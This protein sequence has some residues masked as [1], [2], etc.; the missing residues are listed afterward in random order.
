VPGVGWAKDTGNGV[1][2]RELHWRH[3]H[4]IFAPIHAQP[5]SRHGTLRATSET[6]QNNSDT[7]K[8]TTTSTSCV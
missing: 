8:T 4:L 1:A 3:R 7:V 6:P 2:L 5:A